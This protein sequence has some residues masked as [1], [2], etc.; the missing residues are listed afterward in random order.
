MP[1][2]AS[3]KSK[4]FTK[5]NLFMKKKIYSICVSTDMFWCKSTGCYQ[6]NQFP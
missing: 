2:F 4:L 1:N 6:L 5:Q 3:E